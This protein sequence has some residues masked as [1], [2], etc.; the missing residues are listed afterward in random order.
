MDGRTDE[1]ILNANIVVVPLRHVRVARC[2]FD[3]DRRDE[4]LLF[5]LTLPSNARVVERG[6]P[7]LTPLLSRVPVPVGLRH[8]NLVQGGMGPAYRPPPSS[9]V[10]GMTARVVRHD[11]T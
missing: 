11:M 2:A 10:E 7:L 1:I 4:L 6:T 3:T 8:Q 9:P 5:E